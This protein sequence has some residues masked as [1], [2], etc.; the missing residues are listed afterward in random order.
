[1]AMRAA[2]S[3]KNLRDSKP[4][5][6][7]LVRVLQSDK[8]F[9]EKLATKHSR[10]MSEIFHGIIEQHKRQ[11]FFNELN[12]AYTDLRLNKRA[13]SAELADRRIFE[14]TLADGL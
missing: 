6:S 9:L 14:S 3:S 11:G 2:K 7:T 5:A 4:N 12:A 8:K 10:S 13:W 1:M